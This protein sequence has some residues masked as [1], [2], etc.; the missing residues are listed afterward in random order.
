MWR[1]N[2]DCQREVEPRQCLASQLLVL[3]ISGMSENFVRS[4]T[5]GIEERS[6]RKHILNGL[7]RWKTFQMD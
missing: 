4:D 7:E 2:E 3:L 6:G 5:G 1:A